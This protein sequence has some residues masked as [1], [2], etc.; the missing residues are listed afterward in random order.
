MNI[1]AISIRN[2]IPI[3]I[4]FLLSVLL[5]LHSFWKINVQNFPDLSLPTIVINGAL[6]GATPAQLENDVAKKIENAIA[7][8]EGLKNTKS[9]LKDG[10]VS[11]TAEFELEKDPQ[12]ALDE[13]RAAVTQVRSL[14]PAD[15]DEPQ[16][17]RAKFSNTPVK[18]YSI[19]S[20]SLSDE[21]LSWY[22][23]NE[24]TKA[25]LE[26]PGVAQVTLVGGVQREI[27]VALNPAALQSVGI[28][29]PEVARQLRQNQ[30][31]LP[32]GAL[33]VQE[34]S[35]PVRT[36]SSESSTFALKD[37]PIALPG[38]AFIP[39]E[40]IAHISDTIQTPTAS[41]SFDGKKVIG[42]EI[43]KSSSA[44]ELQL[45]KRLQTFVSD[46]VQKNPH[47]SI[48][49]AFDF[50][51]PVKNT[52][53]SSLQLLLEGALLAVLVV[54]LF[55]KDWRATIVSAC[56]LPLSI[57]PT[58]A[59]LYYADFTI[60]VIT[61]L[62]LSLVVG[63][64]VDDAIV[65]VEN[66]ERHM[67]EGKTP[68]QAAIEATQEIGLAVVATTFTLVAVFLPTAFM[69]GIPGLVFKQFGWTAAISVFASLVVARLLT[70][71]MAAY[72]LKNKDPSKREHYEPRWIQW[73]SKLAAW[74]IANRI[75]TIALALLFFIASLAIIP[76]LPKGFI[77]PNN[78]NQMQ[79]T[80][81]LPPGVS[82]AQMQQTV[83]LIE[84]TLANNPH[85]QHIYSSIGSGT[86]SSRHDGGSLN[87]TRKATVALK[88][89]P[90]NE[91]PHKQHIEQQLTQAL[92]SIPGA[93]ISFSGSSSGS[94]YNLA[95]V[96]D[97]PQ[98]LTLAA[99]QVQ[100][101]LATISGLGSISA[102]DDLKRTEVSIRIDRT[103]MALYGV[104]SA[105]LA[106]T[107]R[108]ATL[109]EPASSL[110]KVNTSVRQVPITVRLNDD[111][112]SDPKNLLELQVQAN[113]GL[114]PLSELASFSYTAD[115]ST[116][117]RLNRE[118]TV[119]FTIDL[120]T[121][122]LGDAARTIKNLPALGALPAAVR[123]LETGDAERMAELFAGFGLAMLTGIL[124]I[125]LILVLLFKDFLQP[126]TILVALP[127][128]LGGAFAGLLL[129]GNSFSMP[130]LIGLIM[131][132]GV[133]TKNS[134]LLVDYAIILKKEGIS[135]AQATL[136]ACVKRARPIVMT[137][138]AMGLGMLPVALDLGAGD[139]SFRAPMAIAV[140]GGLL[141]STL[142]S[143]LVIPAVFTL[144]EDAKAWILRKN[145]PTKKN[146]SSE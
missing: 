21:Q 27:L 88:L 106:Q 10:S 82:L 121:I 49:E 110:P 52:Y 105:A 101:Q 36:L 63:I 95:L 45:E 6:L 77:P 54:Y 31:D 53:Y 15:M 67:L 71:L 60:N 117:E 107:L 114:I 74:S 38:G 129:T 29:A 96:S 109:G 51:E 37:F 5:G 66:I 9:V 103:K 62:A 25:L 86:A 124:C 65:E 57:I 100:Q 98:A 73:Y 79:I 120:G 144:V 141:T 22:V 112:I 64:L 115:A 83:S 126:L 3:L 75:K 8:L 39:L 26:I 85:I 44:N 61:L 4:F 118:R 70:P 93:K 19:A 139:G 122:Q 87:E 133:A 123:I 134:I 35:I 11:I 59:F 46:V 48:Q 32:S 108:I 80:V 116:I 28:S 143:L 43:K 56:A 142:L 55:L 138:I 24:M 7:P 111:F 119:N 94:T 34:A 146:P 92:Q 136:E 130:S 40:Q 104:S 113:T 20:S 78:A 89:N 47:L 81:E 97:E 135:Q 17:V 2:P 140:I 99:R 102:S 42:F 14:L 69:G 131:L 1:S 84:K 33:R 132:M 58:F 72:L 18:I 23:Q 68:Y 128:S 50:I 30:S 13:V 76:M 90:K 91:R 41:A 125:Y 127:L 145:K 137:T 16:V 12:E